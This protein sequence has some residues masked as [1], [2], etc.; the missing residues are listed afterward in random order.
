[1]KKQP[2]AKRGAQ[3]NPNQELPQGAEGAEGNLPSPYDSA[4]LYSNALPPLVAATATHTQ[5]AAA[6]QAM[7]AQTAAVA[8]AAA[9]AA[10]QPPP[11]EDCIKSQTMQ[12][13]SR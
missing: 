11:Y 13:Q 9:Q 7:A 8:A 6:A 1:M 4:S 3:P 10:K 12:Q 2:P 5:T